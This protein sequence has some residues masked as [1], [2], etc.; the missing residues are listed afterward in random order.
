MAPE[1]VDA[2]GG[3]C[4]DSLVAGLKMLREDFS[5]AGIERPSCLVM[6]SAYVTV[7]MPR[8]GRVGRFASEDGVS[9]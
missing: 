6:P 5:K 3:R 4:V 2:M 7:P 1:L 9:V 8:T